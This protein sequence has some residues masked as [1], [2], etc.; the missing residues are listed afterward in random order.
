MF[1]R[2]S[3][4]IQFKKFDKENKGHLPF[5]TVVTVVQSM[6]MN[7]TGE[8]VTNWFKEHGTAQPGE[9]TVEEFVNWFKT[10]NPNVY[11]EA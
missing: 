5:A 2:D 10:T 1:T 11:K 3:L 6:G 7:T 4:T 9:V 8:K